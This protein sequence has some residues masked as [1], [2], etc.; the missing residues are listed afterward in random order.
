MATFA[1]AG[2]AYRRAHGVNR[3]ILYT[4]S[5][6]VGCFD[7]RRMHDELAALAVGESATYAA[8]RFVDGPADP[9]PIVITREN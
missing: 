9:P 7:R 1:I 3:A 8:L 6:C 2:S 5:E 4:A